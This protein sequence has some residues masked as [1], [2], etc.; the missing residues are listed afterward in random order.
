MSD[1]NQD[2]AFLFDLAIRTAFQSKYKGTKV[3]AVLVK[4]WRPIAVG[5]N[6]YPRGSDDDWINLL[7]REDRLSLAI[8]AEEN[9]LFNAADA[10]VSVKGCNVFVTHHPCISC[11]SKMQSVGIKNILYIKNPNLEKE[12]IAP[13]A[14]LYE[15][16]GRN[17]RWR[18][19]DSM[20]GYPPE[21][22]GD[23]GSRLIDEFVRDDSYFNKE[24]KCS[25]A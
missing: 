4:D 1:T 10:G 12:W 18:L 21:Q 24:P 5:C 17:L 20:Y 22:L 9:V 7:P 2:I 19:N 23:F 14:H 11:F 3:G 8:H 13:K 15:A 25:C 16:V 6:G